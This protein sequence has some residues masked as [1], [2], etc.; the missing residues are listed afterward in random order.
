MKNNETANER[1]IIDIAG[2]QFGFHDVLVP[3]DKYIEHKACYDIMEPQPYNATETQDVD[4]SLSISSVVNNPQS[5]INLMW[6]R[7]AR[8]HFADFVRKRFEKFKGSFGKEMLSGS[9][10]HFQSS[11]GGFIEQLKV[12]MTGFVKQHRTES[13]TETQWLQG[14]KCF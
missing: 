7:A 1:W 8:L 5:R 14:I 2:C 13:R 11:L 12:H 9:L 6:E 3:F 10:S 4:H